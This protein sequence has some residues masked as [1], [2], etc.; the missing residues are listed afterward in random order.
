MIMHDLKI[1]EKLYIGNI[2]IQLVRVTGENCR[3]GFEAP[4]EVEIWRE[5]IAPRKEAPK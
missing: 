1:H 4:D 5:E 3:L 2:C